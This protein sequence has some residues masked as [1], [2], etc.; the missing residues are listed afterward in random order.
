MV[1][2]FRDRCI[3]PKVRPSSAMDSDRRICRSWWVE[4]GL[5]DTAAEPVPDQIGSS[6][7]PTTEPCLSRF[8]TTEP[9]LS[10][11]ARPRRRYSSWSCRTPYNETNRM[12][13]T[14]EPTWIRDFMLLR[15]R[16]SPL[17]SEMCPRAEIAR[18]CAPRS[19]AWRRCACCVPQMSD[20]SV[21]HVTLRHTPIGSAAD[22]TTRRASLAIGDEAAVDEERHAVDVG[23]GVGAQPHCGLRDLVGRAP[24]GPSAAGATCAHPDPGARRGTRASD[25]SR[26]ARGAP[27]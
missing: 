16:R 6:R 26:S 1:A 4:I 18:S 2:S 21:I 23:G 7:L 12:T 9:C 17:S 19:S 25:R 10:R 5:R 22:R 8:P 11:L 20:R 14:T 24:C 27:R 15:R 3:R 13:D